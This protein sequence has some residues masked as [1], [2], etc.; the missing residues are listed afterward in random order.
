MGAHVVCICAWAC[1]WVFDRACK[2][3]LEGYGQ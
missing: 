2:R 1:G 3:W